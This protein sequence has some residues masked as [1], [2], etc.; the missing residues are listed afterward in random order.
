[1][2]ISGL[3]V[4]LPLML[5]A[6]YLVQ[7]MSMAYAAAMDAA[8]A[9]ELLAKTHTINVKCNVL[10]ADQGQQLKDFVARAEISLA[11]KNSVALARKTISA[12]R[13]AGNAAICDDTARKLVNDVLAAASTAAAA[14]VADAT[15]AEIMSP[16][17][18]PEPLKSAALPTQ[19][20]KPVA[21]A[22]AVAEPVPVKKPVVKPVAKLEPKKQI[23]I[24]KPDKPKVR[25]KTVKRE[26]PLKPA[27]GL[28]SYARVAETYYAAIR[29]GSMSR[30]GISRLYKTVLTSHQQA[31]ASNRPGAVRAMLRNAETKAAGRSCT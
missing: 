12:G 15:T 3:L 25:V 4:S 19:P 23:V 7:P 31:V 5:G 16:K 8:Q 9:T 30:S 20:K 29:C 13:T 17:P 27:K 21:A 28:D 18:E 6:T 26:K 14:P 24:E 1:M 10:S 22:L 11:E 2:R